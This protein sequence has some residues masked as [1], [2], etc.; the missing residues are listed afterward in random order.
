[1]SQGTVHAEEKRSERSGRHSPFPERPVARCP[2]WRPAAFS[3]PRITDPTIPKQLG[4]EAVGHLLPQDGYLVLYAALL[5][6]QR[7]L[8]DALDGK[9]LAGRLLFC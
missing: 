3:L 4:K 8:R 5:A 9:E 6:L 2:T 1:M 7:L